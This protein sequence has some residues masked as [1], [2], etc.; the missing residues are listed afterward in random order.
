MRN[1]CDYHNQGNGN[2][3]GCRQWNGKKCDIEDKIK[4]NN[5]TQLVHEP[6]PVTGRRRGSGKVTGILR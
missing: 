5:K 2:C 3:I 4:S 1:N 6:F